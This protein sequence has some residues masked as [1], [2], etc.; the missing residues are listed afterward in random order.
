MRSSKT[1]RLLLALAAGLVVFAAA[2]VA[3]QAFALLNWEAGTCKVE[4]CKDSEAPANT[5][6]FYTQAAGHPNY[7]ITDFEFKYKEAEFLGKKWKEPEGRVDDVRV[8]L[9]PGLAINPEATEVCQP[10][11]LKDDE[12]K[13]PKGSQVG[14]DQATGTAEILAG[15]KETVTEEFPVYNMPRLPGEPS[16]FGIEINSVTLKA[17]N[18]QGVVYLEGGISWQKEG[19]NSETS[20]VTTGDYHEFFRIPNIPEQPEIIESRLI[21]WGVPEEHTGVGTPTAFITLP[22]TCS[23]K[24]ITYL[25]ASSHEGSENF[26]YEKNQTPVTAT[27]CDQ[28]A[29][30]PSVSLTA[31]TSQSD[32]PDGVSVDLH[33][34]QPLGE[35]SKP[36]SPD[37]QNAEVTLPEGM[38]LNPSA[39]NGLQ[40]CSD[41]QFE[42][43]ACPSAS[44]VGSFS[45]NAPGIPPGSLSGGVYVGAPEAA[46]GAETGGE[47]R[48]F[49]IG[50]TPKVAGA[51]GPGGQYGVGLRLEGR[52]KANATT[53]RLTAAFAN[54]PQVPFED[55]QLHFRGGARAPVANPLACGAVAPSGAIAPYGGEPAANAAASGFTVAGCASPLPFALTQ[56]L[57]PRSPAKAGAYDPATFGL[58]R[59]DGQQY[60]SKISTT[61][62]AGL[63]GAIPSVPLCGE[64]QASA[65]TCAATS[66]IGTVAI[67][68]GAGSEPYAFTGRAYLT[69]PYD[70]APYGLSVVVPAVAGPYDLG[71]VVTRAALS[72]G[73]YSGRVTV[74]SALPTIVGG[75]PL[76]LKSLSVSVNRPSF[77]FNPTDCSALATESLLG[78]TF[79]ASQSL[80]SPFQVQGCNTLPF[81]PSLT[82]DSGGRTS[83]AGGASI[84]VKIAQGAHQANLREVQLQL[85]PQLVARGTTLQK[86]CLQKEFETGPPPGVCK[87]TSLVGRATVVT[88]VLPG[89]LTGKAYLVSHAAAAFPDLDLVLEGDG[90]HFVLVGHTHIGHSGVTTSTFETIPDVP[91]S[92]VIVKLPFGPNS[93]LSANGRVCGANLIAPTT[94]IAQSGT[95]ITRNTRIA[96]TGCPIRLLSH[97]VR[98][99]RMILT[100]WVPEKGRVTVSGRGIRGVRARLK[101]AGVVKL[102]LALS[103]RGMAAVHGHGPRLALKLGFVPSAGHNRSA[104]KASLR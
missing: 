92:S 5:S 71:D 50:E 89:S 12:G 27:G 74:T 10:E 34:P 39:A 21:F 61:L 15:I 67:A 86:A 85:P 81:K 48:I 33:V 70:G 100:L 36:D 22:S 49:L 103:S 75:V 63:I 35:P 58:S 95:K 72:V 6:A 64:P 43:R 53:G 57:K 24:P 3:A 46:M 66:E 17:L 25:H 38:T 41:T 82:A 18:L 94:I 16:R 62:P 68:A 29:F 28:L 88:P 7:G 37:V 52:V 45:V 99:G 26:I 31:E 101:K 55:L 91:V 1:R 32:Q 23:S 78:S 8:D 93:A 44:S 56:S 47:Y 60:L 2:P 19:P 96:V 40:A 42:G 80:P 59:G 11:T 9:P 20:N 83:K 102:S 14:V 54:A 4:T 98:G 104:L 69:G 13:C 76:R 77:L 97:R 87:S 51:E 65:G 30:N 90:V 73:L 84:E 79:G